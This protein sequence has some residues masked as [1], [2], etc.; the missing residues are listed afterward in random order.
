MNESLKAA[1]HLFGLVCEDSSDKIVANNLK[2]AKI[3]VKELVDA[4]NKAKDSSSKMDIEKNI[5]EAIK[6][7][8]LVCSNLEAALTY[9]KDH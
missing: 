1:E 3:I 2:N 5:E 8:D 7:C 9:S 6:K 4:I